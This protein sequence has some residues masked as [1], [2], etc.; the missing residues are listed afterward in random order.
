VHKAFEETRIILKLILGCLELVVETIWLGNGCWRRK[1]EWALIVIK[2]DTIYER[3]PIRHRRIR[4]QLIFQEESNRYWYPCSKIGERRR[5]E[6][7]GYIIC[8]CF[9][10]RRSRKMFKAT[11]IKVERIDSKHLHIQTTKRVL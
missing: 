5:W 10:I 1:R 6:S 7:E 9:N 4:H 3:I 8:R 2:S 11:W